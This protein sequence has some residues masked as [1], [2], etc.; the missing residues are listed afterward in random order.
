MVEIS[1]TMVMPRKH[2][3]FVGFLIRLVREKPLGT[4]GAVIVVLFLFA[5]IFCEAL[6]PYGMNK[7]D[8][9][10]FLAPPS[11]QHLLGT[12]NLGRDILSRVIYGARISVIVG[13]AATSVSITV[14][15]LIGATCGFFGGKFDMI[16][17]RFVDAFM[18]FPGL[19]LLIALV[20]V[21]GQGIW[22]LILILG[23]TM[24][25][26]GSRVLRS[27][28]LSVR[29]NVYIDAAEAIGCSVPTI[30][31]RHILP[32]VM[33][34][35]I[36]LFSS[37]M[38]TVIMSEAGLSFLGL[39][40]PP[41]YPTWGGMLSGSGRQYMQLAP[42]MA[43]WPGLALSVVIYGVNMFGD[44]L[45]DLLDPRLRGSSGSY[46]VRKKRI[47]GGRHMR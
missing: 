31:F 46:G 21:V 14:S 33:A 45:R 18:C 44:A 37:R 42:W 12:D 27:A 38:P 32:N 2:S 9:T 40:V 15:I 41:P 6:A 28:V 19:V 24:G 17:Q 39:G 30:I 1:Q 11:A 29:V 4:V 26:N 5:A 36:I 22:Q 7:I 3:K 10:A 47:W 16:A 13:L 8:R 43:I 35:I 25:I 23:I 20:A 34:P